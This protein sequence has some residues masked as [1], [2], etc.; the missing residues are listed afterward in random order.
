MEFLK[1]LT[2]Q[3]A[4]Y[5]LDAAFESLSDDITWTLLGEETIHGKAKF[6]AELERMKHIRVLELSISSLLSHGKE[7][8][9]QGTMLMETGQKFGFA[10][11]YEF[12]SAKGDKVKSIKSYIVQLA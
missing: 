6:R 12:S 2:I 7:G 1:E 3:F 5:D 9:V 10:D 11:F 8:A 4:A